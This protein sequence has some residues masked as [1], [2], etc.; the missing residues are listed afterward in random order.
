MP[1]LV[2]TE[3]VAAIGAAGANVHSGHAAERFEVSTAITQQAISGGDPPIAK[4]ILQCYLLKAPPKFPYDLRK[5]GLDP[6][7]TSPVKP[8]QDKLSCG[9]HYGAEALFA[10]LEKTNHAR[11]QAI[12]LAEE[13]DI[14]PGK[15]H[16]SIVGR[17]QPQ[18]AVDVFRDGFDVVIAE[19]LLPGQPGESQ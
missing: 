14:L 17:S 6:D 12:R 9:T 4:L 2:Q 19:A 13:D 5:R 15:L 3:N 8:A 18:I 11:C 16:G 10:I 7:K 1:V